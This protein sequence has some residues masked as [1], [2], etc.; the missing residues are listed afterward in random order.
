MRWLIYGLVALTAAVFFAIFTKDNP[1]YVM[2]AYNEWSI[3]MSAVLLAVLLTALFVALYYTIRFLLGLKA[4][5]GRTL[6]W[7]ATRKGTKAHEGLSRGL[8]T[9][10]EGKWAEAEK[11]L[12]KIAPNSKTPVLIY[13]GAARA[14]HGLG[15]MKKRDAFL[16]EAKKIAREQKYPKVV[17]VAIG[18]TQ[19]ELLFL[20]GQYEQSLVVLRELRNVAPKNKHILLLLVKANKKLDNWERIRDLLPEI[21]KQK[22]MTYDEMYE[23]SSKCHYMLLIE[24]GHSDDVGDVLNV[25]ERVPKDQRAEKKFILTFCQLLIEKNNTGPAESLLKNAVNK[26]WDTDLVYMYGLV[27][28]TNAASQLSYAES[29]IVGHDTDP[30]LM[31]T[32]GRLCLRNQL[33]GKAIE[34]LEICINHHGRPE[35]YY[36]LARL[37]ERMGEK[38]RALALFLQGLGESVE[39]TDIMLPKQ[40]EPEELE[41][42]KRL[43]IINV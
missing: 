15:A 22:I 43:T 17:D 21:S 23:L 34:F 18:I 2:L 25:W 12:I 14:A 4:I 29:W 32:L 36:I 26:S 5:P 6:G 24:A 42:P 35:A 33:W 1:G 19:A 9:L 7:Q 28:G 31:L 11:I 10:A 37:L 40:A 41:P 8:L 38:D 13:L 3:E 39:K 30:D 16:L 20:Q 27:N